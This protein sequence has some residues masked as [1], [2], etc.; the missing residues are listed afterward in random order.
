[1]FNQNSCVVCGHSIADPICSRCYTNQT[2]ILLHDLRI[3]PMI[4]EYINNKLKNHFST[5]TIN[6]AECI[7]CRSDVTT[8]CHYCFSAVLLRILLEL[9]FPEDLVNIMGCKP[10]YEEI[11][12]Q[13]QRS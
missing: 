10:V 13:E 2:M 8:V 6:D 5:E 3:D 9:N 4:K 1:M 7:S 11:Y 12:L